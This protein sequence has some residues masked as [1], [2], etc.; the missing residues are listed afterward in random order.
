M[1]AE[2]LT[3]AAI[4]V[5]I[6][7]ACLIAPLHGFCADGGAGGAR[8]PRVCLVL[9]GGGARGTAHIGVLKVLEELRVPVDCI[10]GTSMGALIGAAYA[11]GVS[12]ADMQAVVT[13]LT[14]ESLFVDRPPRSEQPIRS[15]MDEKL[16][17]I[18]PEFGLKDGSLVL[19][20]GIVAG[21]HLESFLRH[22]NRFSDVVQF[23]DLA[24]PFR[25]V[26]TDL[27]DGQT[28][29]LSRGQLAAAVRASISIPVALAPAQL[30]GRTL[31]D[32]GLTDNLPMD[33]ALQFGADV[34]IVVDLG[35]SRVKQE[36]LKTYVGMTRQIVNILIMQNE[37]RARALVR[38]TDILIRPEV[39]DYSPADFDDWAAPIGVGEAAARKMRD[40]LSALSLSPEDYAA[41]EA[42][43][44]ATPPAGAAIDDLRLPA[45]ERVNPS[46]VRAQ[47]HDPSGR[48]LDA[49]QLETD[50]RRLYAERDFERVG[51]GLMDESGRKV[52]MIDAVE[53]SWGPNFLRFGLQGGTDLR[54]ESRFDVLASLRRTWIDSLGG[55]WRSDLRLGSDEQLS[56]E[57]YLPLD[58]DRVFFVA[59]GVQLQRRSQDVFGSDRREA[60]YVIYDARAGVDLGARIGRAAELRAGLL[61]G[62]LDQRLD[63]GEALLAPTPA[64][65]REGAWRLQ[66]QV[67]ELDRPV[68]PRSGYEASGS[69]WSSRGALG[70]DASYT[71]W[72]L[73]ASEAQ[74]FG[75][76]TLDLGVN[77]GGRFGGGEL[78]HYQVFQWGGFLHQSGYRIGA[79]DGQ[80]LQ[81][82]RAVY[83]YK[84][85][86]LPLLNGLYAG[87]SVEA[88]RLGRPISSDRPTGTM[89]SVSMFL[90]LDGPIGPI[91]LAYGRAR[92]G[93]SSVYL[94]LG[95]P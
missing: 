42:R 29:V 74:S 51:Y 56:S 92:S 33:V 38:P 7:A 60:R 81:F 93:A 5:A 94:Y 87:M 58:V 62:G 20:K 80:S 83:E 84:L 91:Y 13:G 17:F 86:P 11:T 61:T 9:S 53:K 16:N 28:V 34:A 69:L 90:L 32:G 68:V 2:A 31:V 59:P 8:R 40:R 50:L 39:D 89:K 14:G 66:M 6:V 64:H 1:T 21:A 35:S 36:D 72:E 70:A 71:R 41:W 15:K 23:D 54:G 10:A 37:V 44:R 18:G 48:P 55:E 27:A 26:A 52:L 3:C 77:F 49:D 19:P 4:R 30:D 67:D 45:F 65:V 24:I 79:L 12:A 82:A 47:L 46:V 85:A 95:Q 73:G 57:L 88:G 25:A 63:Q 75:D 22:L 43:R 76:N 78:P